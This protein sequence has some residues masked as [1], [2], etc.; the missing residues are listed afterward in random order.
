MRTSE[1][2]QM[3]IHECKLALARNYNV[4]PSNA[5]EKLHI[6]SNIE[7]YKKELEKLNESLK[8]EINK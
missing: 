5:I 4:V 3:N 8:L 2:I 7:H 6:D 1:S